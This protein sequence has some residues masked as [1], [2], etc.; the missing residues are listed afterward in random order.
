M[1]SWRWRSRSGTAPRCW[2]RCW[3]PTSRS[4]TR[5][6]RSRKS[7]TSATSSPTRSSSG[8]TSTFVTPLDREDIHALARSLDDVMDA[9]DASATRRPALQIE[10]VRPDARELARI[11]KA[12]PTQVVKALKALERRKGVAE[13][14]VE[15]NRLENEADRAAPDRGAAALRGGARPHRDHEVEGDSRLPRGRHRPLRGRRQR[16]SK[17]S[18]S[19]TPDRMDTNLLAVAALIVVALIFDYINGFHDAANSIATVVST[20]VLTPG[21]A[22]DLGGVL[23]LRRRLHLRHGGRQDRRL[24]PGRHQRRHASP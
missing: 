23:Q 20:R 15:I 6:T 17:A 3:R 4:G 8:C 9:I 7:S 1:I 22:V 5:R 2:R 21:K 14:A 16:R 24:R 11:I 13:A 19:S 18:S 10:Q 12:W